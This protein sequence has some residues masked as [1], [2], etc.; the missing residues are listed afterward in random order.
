MK[1]LQIEFTADLKLEVKLERFTFPFILKKQLNSL[2]HDNI[3]EIDHSKSLS[4]YLPDLVQNKN[5]VFTKNI[6]YN[7]NSDV[8]FYQ[9]GDEKFIIDNS[10]MMSTHHYW[11]YD[12]I[13]ILKK[14]VFKIFNID[15]PNIPL[16]PGS[17]NGSLVDY[18]ENILGGYKKERL[19]ILESEED[20]SE[21]KFYK[22]HPDRF[23]TKWV[24]N[25][26]FTRHATEKVLFGEKELTILKSNTWKY[27]TLLKGDDTTFL[28]WFK[29]N[30][31]LKV[32]WPLFKLLW[33]YGEN[34]N[35]LSGLRYETPFAEIYPR[36]QE[37][38]QYNVNN[39][40]LEKELIKLKNGTNAVEI[41]KFI[42]EGLVRTPSI[43]KF[44]A[45]AEL[46]GKFKGFL[47]DIGIKL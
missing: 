23:V 12:L 37:H 18:L 41:D 9:I 40:R 36:I 10:L 30:Y 22:Q 16:R 8:A 43:S 45:F 21:L 4:L 39:N 2:D 6:R 31:H 38:L 17:Y 32:T 26:W 1:L 47:N 7:F 29:K 27:N 3:T 24:E 25:N 33:A 15:I 19:Y 11:E 46:K 28:N 44:I 5:N 34:V 13:A 35:N 20:L 42:E 14:D